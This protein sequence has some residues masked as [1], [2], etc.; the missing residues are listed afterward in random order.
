MYYETDV[1]ELFYILGIYLGNG[2]YITR[3]I[4]RIL[5]TVVTAKLY[6][7][8]LCELVRYKTGDTNHPGQVAKSNPVDASNLECDHWHSF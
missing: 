2:M 4:E 5:V 1:R 6:A 3:M 7:I 8:K